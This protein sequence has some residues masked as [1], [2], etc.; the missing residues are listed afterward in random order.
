MGTAIVVASLFKACGLNDRQIR[1]IARKTR[2]SE[3]ASGKINVPRLLECVCEEIV[4][5]TVSYNDLAARVEA[6]TGD[7][8]SRQAYW[9][10]MNTDACIAFFKAIL[11]II[12]LQKLNLRKVA[13][14]MKCALYKRILIQDSTIIQLPSRLFAIFSGVRNAHTTACNAHR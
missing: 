10:R 13:P 2:F 3:R 7:L 5:G 9:E 4:K 11:A 12:M 8:V 14:L 6:V 1:K